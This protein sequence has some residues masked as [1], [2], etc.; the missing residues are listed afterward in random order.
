MAAPNYNLDTK[1]AGLDS[2]GTGLSQGMSLASSLQQ[3][4]T[5]RMQQD[6]LGT[7]GAEEKAKAA[8]L[9]QK[10]A[11]DLAKTQQETETSKSSQRAEE[12]RTAL[13]KTQLPEAAAR[14]AAQQAETQKTLAGVPGELAKSTAEKVKADDAIDAHISNSFA[15]VAYARPEDQESMFKTIRNEQLNKWG[16]D[17]LAVVPTDWNDSAKN[18]VKNSAEIHPTDPAQREIVGKLTEADATGRL[19][20][21]SAINAKE[22]TDYN[23]AIKDSSSTAADA[24]QMVNY[25]NQ[26]KDAYDK[27]DYKGSVLGKMPSTGI[28]TIGQDTTQ[29]Q[30]ADNAAQNMQQLVL[31]LMKTNRLTNY[32]LNFAGGLKLNRTMNPETIKEVGDFLSAKSDRLNEEPEMLNAAAHAG[33]SSSDAKVLVNRYNMERPVYDFGKHEIIKN[34]LRTFSDYLNKDA[35]DAIHTG[36]PYSP[37]LSSGMTISIVLPNGKT[38]EIPSEN[39]NEAI[40]RMNALGT[41]IGIKV[42]DK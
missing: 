40:R 21:Q 33:L 32:E 17:K 42:L 15:N 41:G 7:V 6:Y 10:L 3:L 23:A 34:N 14:I 20:A 35:V 8:N 27:S 11:A 30:I 12:M 5:S 28:K 38:G 9:P 24:N 37:K 1:Q 29:E 19:K 31:K 16:A 2:I 13:E 36:V 4:Q 39:L 22:L 25:I 18:F 26:F